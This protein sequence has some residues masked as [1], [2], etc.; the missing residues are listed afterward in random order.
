VGNLIF[1]GTADDELPVAYAS[2]KFTPCKARYSAIERELLAIVC[3]VEH[4][5]LYL[6]ERKFLLRNDQNE[7]LAPYDLVQIKGG[8]MAPL[9]PDEL[10]DLARKTHEQDK[11]DGPNNLQVGA[12]PGTANRRW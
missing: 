1:Q 11:R 4:F 7:R 12:R 10:Y 5:R 3:A 9:R 6:L 2:K 8:R